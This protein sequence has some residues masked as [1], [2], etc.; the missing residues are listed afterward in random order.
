MR[1]GGGGLAS[2][3][4]PWRRIVITICLALIAGAITR[5]LL[6]AAEHAAEDLSAT[7]TADE[8]ADPR[9][10]G[11]ATATTSNR[12]I[13]ST[14]AMSTTSTRTVPSMP[15]TSASSLNRT[16]PSTS[17]VP[18]PPVT[19]ASLKAAALDIEEY[20]NGLVIDIAEEYGDVDFL[21]SAIWTSPDTAR[22]LG[23]RLAAKLLLGTL[24]DCNDGSPPSSPRF[25]FGGYSVTVGRGNY[26]SQSW[27]NIA[28]ARLGSLFKAMGNSL[29]T[30]NHGH[31]GAP[32]LP[33]GWCLATILGDD[34]DLVSWEFTLNEQKTR[35]NSEVYL[36]EALSLP[37]KPA[38]LFSDNRWTPRLN[39]RYTMLQQYSKQG[40]PVLVLDVM[41]ALS[42]ATARGINVSVALPEEGRRKSPLPLE[43][44]A[45]LLPKMRLAQLGFKRIRENPDAILPLPGAL[46]MSMKRLQEQGLVNVTVINGLGEE[47]PCTVSNWHPGWRIQKIAGDA[48]ALFVAGEIAKAV[49]TLLEEEFSYEAGAQNNERAVS[50]QLVAKLHSFLPSSSQPNYTLPTPG[51]GC[52]PGLLCRNDLSDSNYTKNILGRSPQVVACETSF[53]PRRQLDRGLFIGNGRWER[54]APPADL[55]SIVHSRKCGVSS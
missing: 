38:V 6:R 18:C 8:D 54:T 22:A 50:K 42:L 2:R 24:S 16:E 13:P 19:L 10:L 35:A 27:P 40:W 3:R 4:T 21:R 44:L 23:S 20:A 31:G 11:N 12:T 49:P 39:P 25:A 34:A 14:P 46:R 41:G 36:R 37:S 48:L 52:G 9:P 30:N 28:G 33:Y 26:H 1:I 45:T 43:T 47:A 51:A 55:T 15:A 53:E 5:Q 17:P 7:P 32:S 29:E